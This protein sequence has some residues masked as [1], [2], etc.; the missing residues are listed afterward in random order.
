MQR[1]VIVDKNDKP[2]DLKTYDELKYDDIYRVSALWLADI[3]GNDVLITQRK[4]TKHH[5]PGKWM[6][7][8]SG[9][10]DE[11][12]TYEQNVVKEI[13]EE[14]GLT[15]LDL[16]VGPKE[17]VADKKHKFFVQWFSATVDKSKVSIKIQKEEV[18]A[19]SWINKVELVQDVEE[20]PGKYVP[21]MPNALKILG[22]S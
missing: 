16:A 12:E 7:A 22:V 17:F 5:D 13:E 6:A 10:V 2:I 1:I 15:N 8:A 14:I 18:E 3:N 19:Y 21:S 11:G 9:T 4:W 20:H